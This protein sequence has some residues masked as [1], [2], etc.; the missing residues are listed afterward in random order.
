MASM[1][2]VK[3]VTDKHWHMKIATLIFTGLCRKQRNTVLHRQH[4]RASSIFFFPLIGY[5]LFIQALHAHWLLKL[6]RIS[7][8]SLWEWMA[9]ITWVWGGLEWQ[10][11]LKVSFPAADINLACGTGPQE[12]PSDSLGDSS[13]RA[14]G[15]WNQV[16]THPD[17]S[18]ISQSVLTKRQHGRRRRRVEATRWRTWKS[19]R[20]WLDAQP[21][22]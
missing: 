7:R 3:Q 5:Q 22:S 16:R 19:Q 18:G 2:G 9:E 8:Q 6:W 17:K 21:A 1:R 15:L 14:K 20:T 12:S 13:S 10:I 11:L 4:F